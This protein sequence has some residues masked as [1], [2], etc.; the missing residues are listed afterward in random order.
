MEKSRMNTPTNAY[1]FI[2]TNADLAA[3]SKCTSID[4][5]RIEFCSDCTQATW[6]ALQLQSITGKDASAGLSLNIYATPGITNM[7]GIKSVKGELQG[8][9]QLNGGVDPGTNGLTSLDGA[10][11]ITYVHGRGGSGTLRNYIYVGNNPSLTSA[12][13][14]VNARFP[15]NTDE[16]DNDPVCYSSIY[17][18]KLAS[19]PCF[20]PMGA[21]ASDINI[22]VPHPTCAP[23]PA[24]HSISSVVKGAAI[25]STVAIVFAIIFIT[26][27]LYYKRRR[28]IEGVGLKQSLLPEDGL[29]LGLLGNRASEAGGITGIT[30]L[31]TSNIAQYQVGKYINTI[32]ADGLVVSMAP[33][34][35]GATSG[36]GTVDV[37]VKLQTYRMKKGAEIRLRA[38]PD[39]Q[40]VLTG[41]ILPPGGT[42]EVHKAVVG[43]SQTFL[44]VLGGGWAFEFHPQTGEPV[45]QH[46]S[47]ELDAREAKQEAREAKKA[48]EAAYSKLKSELKGKIASTKERIAT[49]KTAAT[50]ESYATALALQDY[51][52]HMQRIK[53]EATMLQQ[54]A[55]S[56]IS[57]QRELQQQLARLQFE[58]ATKTPRTAALKLFDLTSFTRGQF[59][60]GSSGACE[61]QHAVY[62]VTNTQVVLKLFPE[63]EITT[64]RREAAVFQYLYRAG[65]SNARLFIP[66][67]EGAKVLI[68]NATPSKQ[69]CLPLAK[70]EV[71]FGQMLREA[72]AMGMDQKTREQFCFQM[73]EVLRFLHKCGVVWGDL[74]PSNY[75]NFYYNYQPKLKAIDF[76]ESCVVQEGASQSEVDRNVVPHQF[77]PKDKITPEYC[78]P[79]RM[80]AVKAG[81]D[82]AAS[83]QHDIWSLGM[84][85]YQVLTGRAYFEGK[86]DSQISSALTSKSF[87]VDLSAI[88]SKEAKSTLTQM[89]QANPSARGTMDQVLTKHFFIGGASISGTRIVRIENALQSI[90][91]RLEHLEQELAIGWQHLVRSQH[92]GAQADHLIPLLKQYIDSKQD[93]MREFVGAVIQKLPVPA[94][95]VVNK[96]YFTKQLGLVF[97]CNR[98]RKEFT[99]ATSDWARWLKVSIP[100]VT[101]GAAVFDRAPGDALENVRAAYEAYSKRDDEDFNTFTKEPFILAEERDRLLLQLRTSKDIGGV[102]GEQT[103]FEAFAYD[104]QTGQWQ[105]QPISSA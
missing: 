59:L 11:G 56:T 38:Y 97:V 105:V 88:T 69:H 8:S 101:A 96:G 21:G 48:A 16:Y 87:R 47:A 68:E 79:E 76:G 78:S 34:A 9:I 77:S 84:T 98:T 43:D 20:W 94:R 46:W 63:K 22:Y 75:V 99:V 40:S 1:Y 62:Q 86:T 15:P 52:E 57:A 83:P 28:I 67:I 100:L 71:D 27:F 42:F 102:F 64:A 35:Q 55:N 5:L 49:A 26:G 90:E 82:I 65:G 72:G 29:Q 18:P 12:M 104:A 50:A 103:F 80:N 54:Q 45:C 19:V 4:Y 3:L 58:V 25:G 44:G 37:Q 39:P 23:T 81:K 66:E 85:M 33:D 31:R 95:F 30:Q 73:A 70:G 10:E 7:C 61:L 92:S 6:C 14:L 53:E 2:N 36:P 41:R 51:L 74:K 17:N 93:Q 32:Q 60:Q 89:L 91:E 24:P 13:G